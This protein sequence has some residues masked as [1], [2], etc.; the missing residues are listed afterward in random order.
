MRRF[1]VAALLLARVATR[2]P[3]V[4][5]GPRPAP[6]GGTAALPVCPGVPPRRPVAPR[7]RPLSGGGPLVLSEAETLVDPLG[8]HIARGHPEVGVAVAARSAGHQTLSQE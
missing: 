6:G 8:R 5:P 7:L 3:D 2:G 1:A 4:L